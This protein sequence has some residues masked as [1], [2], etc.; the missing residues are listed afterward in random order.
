MIGCD[1]ETTGLD[2]CA[3]DILEIAL[4]AIAL[5]QFEIV[6]RFSA[7]VAPSVTGLVR[8]REN[9]FVL[10]MHD[11]NGLLA[12]LES[13]VM[14]PEQVEAGALAW[15]DQALGFGQKSP[16]FGVNPNFDRKFLEV[17]MPELASR[18]HYRS[19][20]TNCFHLLRLAIEGK[21]ADAV[22]SKGGTAH[23]AMADI[24]Q[25]VRN[26]HDFVAWITGAAA[27]AE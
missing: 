16:L 21:W 26:V 18:F 7:L 2:A 12:A 9:D 3:D 25:G 6:D 27:A 1:L 11:G 4:V 14:G 22:R 24:E 17:H 15:W 10:K 13:C 19:F 23:R 8:L 5:P 20:D